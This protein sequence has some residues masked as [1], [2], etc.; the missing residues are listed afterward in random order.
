MLL[1][2]ESKI[3]KL[4]EV[5]DEMDNFFSFLGNLSSEVSDLPITEFLSSDDLNDL[6]SKL[7]SS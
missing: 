7:N 1:K 2:V 4:D 3:G 6:R 5:R